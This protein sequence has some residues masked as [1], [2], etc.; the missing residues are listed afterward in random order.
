MSHYAVYDS[1]AEANEYS[2]PALI[3]WLTA[4]SGEQYLAGTT[5]WGAAKQRASDGKWVINLCK[6]MDNVGVVI[7]VIKPDWFLDDS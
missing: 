1:E 3:N 5:R 6:Y 4:H 7:E 2:P